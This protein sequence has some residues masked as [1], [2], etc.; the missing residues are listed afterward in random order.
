MHLPIDVAAGGS[1]TIVVDRLA[2]HNAVLSGIFLGE[3][4]TL[5]TT[6]PALSPSFSS[7]VSD[8]VVR[9]D[10]TSPVDVQVQSPSGSTSSIDGRPASGGTNTASVALNAGQS[11][12]VVLTSQADQ[13]RYHVRCLPSDFPVYQFTSPRRATQQWY[14]V[15]PSLGGGRP[16]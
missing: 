14:I 11:F 1:L 2:G 5:V 10:G 6:T 3:R 13:R 12:D 7:D 4:A 16:Y 9:C 15:T 8:Y